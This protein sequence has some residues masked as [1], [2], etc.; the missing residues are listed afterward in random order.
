MDNTRTLVQCASDLTVR[1]HV[2][3][4]FCM[5][6]SDLLS[7]FIFFSAL[8]VIGKRH[9]SLLVFVFVIF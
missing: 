8:S 2:R 3:E 4:I 6:F 1:L 5:S 7:F 9:F